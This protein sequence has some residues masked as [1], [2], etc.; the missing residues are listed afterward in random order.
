MSQCAVLLQ[1]FVN[2]NNEAV[3]MMDDFDSYDVEEVRTKFRQNIILH[4]ELKI[5]LN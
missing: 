1:V 3:Q 5:K 2:T 4:V